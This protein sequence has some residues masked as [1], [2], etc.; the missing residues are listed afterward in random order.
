[1]EAYILLDDNSGWVSETPVLVPLT[2]RYKTT[3]RSSLQGTGVPGWALGGVVGGGPST[4]MTVGAWNL[5]GCATIGVSVS[6]SGAGAPWNSLYYSQLRKD[7]GNTVTY[8]VGARYTISHTNINVEIDW[9][10]SL[11]GLQ[12]AYNSSLYAIGAV[13]N[14]N[15]LGVEAHPNIDMS[16]LVNITNMN[17]GYQSTN[18]EASTLF[19]F[20]QSY[21]YVDFKHNNGALDGEGEAIQ[22]TYQSLES[23]NLPGVTNDVAGLAFAEAA[24]VVMDTAG[25]GSANNVSGCIEMYVLVYVKNIHFLDPVLPDRMYDKP[26]TDP[27]EI[28]TDMSDFNQNF[29]S[30]GSTGNGST[31]EGMNAFSSTYGNSNLP[32]N[33]IYLTGSNYNSFIAA[34]GGI[35]SNSGIFPI[36]DT[37]YIES[38]KLGVEG[39]SATIKE[40]VAFDSTPSLTIGDRLYLYLFN[41]NNI[42]KPVFY[43]YIT[44]QRR[45]L[46][47]T[48]TEITYECNDLVYF[49][50]QFYTPSHY[51]YRPPSYNG[52]GVVKTYDRV[53]K[54]ILNVAGIPNAILSL[55]TFNSPP[56]KWIYQSLK[57]VL[58]WAT[59]FF[60]NYVYY[61]DRYGRLRFRGVSSGSVVKAYAVGSLSEDNCVESFAPLTDYSRSRSRVVLTGDFE[62][63]EKKVTSY[64]TRGGEL[65]PNENERT[66][67]F[68]FYD[69]TDDDLYDDEDGQEHKFYY[70][71]FKPGETLNDK[72]LTDKNKSCRVIIKN[73]KNEDGTYEDKEISP[74][75]FKSEEGDSEIYC[76]DDA[77]KQSRKIEIIY[78]VRTN[79]PIQVSANTAYDGGTEVVRRPEFKKATSLF[80]SINDIGLMNSYLTI[81]KEFYK[82]V[83]GGSLV[84]DG[85][86]LDINLIDKA[87]ITGTSLSASEAIGLTIYGIT[88][89]CVNLRTTIELSNKTMSNLPFFDVMRERSR[90]KN[91]LLAK[92]GIIEDTLLYRRG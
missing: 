39:S 27:F 63:T 14:C 67:I 20:K 82:P 62:V 89:D 8:R 75:V 71:M 43:G 88:Y 30:S 86:D 46:N 37:L 69:T 58:E 10:T 55:P 21:N 32:F 70:F 12:A 41:D 80:D 85:L 2:W 33:S 26:V 53:L 72:L 66:G 52:S 35:V 57:T 16:S 84:V 29:G 90:N 87:S 7:N 49:L 4:A 51:I 15:S 59:N 6:K 68:W 54:E 56:M 83:S 76:E 9:E 60:G 22:Q 74:R 5:G 11:A 36:S 92:M 42:D 3:T 78:A 50:D 31:E 44:S 61:I 34:G 25:W 45:S 79:S 48:T 81:L 13:R 38:V 40:L 91:E 28:T 77:F 47:G 23:S 17:A 73:Y 19:D 1:M 64:F 18:P 24:N 65:D